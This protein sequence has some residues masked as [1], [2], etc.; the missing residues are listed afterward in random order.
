MTKKI[1]PDRAQIV[2][3]KKAK[4]RYIKFW[5]MSMSITTR[6]P[7]EKNKVSRLYYKLFQKELIHVRKLYAY[8]L[9]YW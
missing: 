7:S 6:T 5:Q 3:I 9:K 1:L 2:H 8:T 4:R